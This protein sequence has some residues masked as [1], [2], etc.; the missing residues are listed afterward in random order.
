MNKAS[1]VKHVIGVV[2]G[3]GGVG[4]SSVTSLLAVMTRRLGYN[5]AILDADITGP[6]IPKMFGLKGE[7]TGCE[8]GIIPLGTVTGID[9]I[10]INMLLNDESAPV[11]W[12]G[13]LI[14]G[15]VKQFWTDV[16]WGD[17]DY[18]YVDMPPGTGD[19]PL[20]VMQSLPLDGIVIVTTPS[21]LVSMIV[22]KAVN[23]ARMMNVPIIGIVEN[24]SYLTCPCCNEK[25]E[26]FGKTHV[27]EIAAKYN[28]PVIARLPIDPKLSALC[29][30]GT[31]ETVETDALDE[32]VNK[33]TT[34]FE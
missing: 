18:M 33:I 29:D 5:T 20:T 14:A 1:N 11:I 13:S 4:K 3:K 31:I 16:V 2:S 8:D 21:D 26:V 10:S 34:V 30:A 19:V 17:V 12:R 28:I 6:S 7:V 15:T 27:D 25:I 24:Y 9:A 23:M 22:S 32:A